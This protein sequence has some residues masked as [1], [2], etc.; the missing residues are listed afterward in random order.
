MNIQSSYDSSVIL[1]SSLQAEA[2]KETFWDVWES[3]S[4][5]IFLNCL[6]MTKNHF[7]DAQD[8]FSEVMLKAYYKIFKCKEEIVCLNNWSKTV[9]R[10]TFVSQYRQRKRF[11][12]YSDFE[13]ALSNYPSGDC[14]FSKVIDNELLQFVSEHIQS[15]PPRYRCLAQLYI[16]GATTNKDFSKDYSVS[17]ENTRKIIQITKEHI[18]SGVK[19]Y[20]SG[21][22]SLSEASLLPARKKLYEHLT[23]LKTN[24]RF[25]VLTLYSSASTHRL[26]QRE[27]SIRKYLD[28]WNRSF[29]RLEELAIVLYSQGKLNEALVILNQMLSEAY[30]DERIFE[31]KIKILNHLKRFDDSKRT[32]AEA[33]NILLPF[34][35][36]LKLFELEVVNRHSEYERLV[37]DLINNNPTHS[38]FREKLIHFYESR[39]MSVSSF[40]QSKS[41]YRYHTNSVEC[42]GPH[43]KNLLKTEGR[44]NALTFL[45]NFRK[46]SPESLTALLFHLH[47]LVKENKDHEAITNMLR[48]IRRTHPWH[49]DYSFLKALI[50]K[51]K[52]DQRRANLLMHNRMED[53][54]TCN[55]SALYSRMIN[56]NYLIPIPGELTYQ[57]KLH[58]E[59][60]KLI[61]SG[62]K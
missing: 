48:K 14:T 28:K 15:L 16:S 39:G 55:L 47:F 41:F 36:S 50:F 20:K 17:E 1:R 24:N 43:F 13:E 38:Y 46:R 31:L 34:P 44:D 33:K 59:T 3:N 56:G 8:I 26:E 42:L 29:S 25:E 12:E 45:E 40:K 10:N 35:V 18:I 19:N 11:V 2:R 53:Y 21:N 61:H 5:R 52:K 22:P 7:H 49:P 58:F 60:V 23:F 6:E 9:I 27:Q 62:D 54:P 37:L 30:I 51:F 32:I 57:E 4:K